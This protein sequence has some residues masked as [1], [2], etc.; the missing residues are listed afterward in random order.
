M[1][2]DYD[3]HEAHVVFAKFPDDIANRYAKLT[4]NKGLSV[5]GRPGFVF[6]AL[7]LFVVLV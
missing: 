2:S 1:D 3:T 7:C 4:V 6:V 5:F